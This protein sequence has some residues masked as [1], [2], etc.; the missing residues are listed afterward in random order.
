MPRRAR[1][2]PFPGNNESLGSVEHDTVICRV[3]YH[4]A[5]AW[6]HAVAGD[7]Q[8]ARGAGVAQHDAIRGAIGGDAPEG[9][10]EVPRPIL[11]R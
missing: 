8:A 2:K 3:P 7:S 10:A 9:H 4:P 11:C 5:G 1:V 6:R